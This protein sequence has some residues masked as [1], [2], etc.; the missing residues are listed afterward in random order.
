[1]KSNSNTEIDRYYVPCE[2]SIY[3]KNQNSSCSLQNLR[4]KKLS[5]SITKCGYPSDSQFASA[6]TTDDTV[7]AFG[8]F[9]W[10]AVVFAN[11][12]YI[13]AGSLIHPK[14]V[15][16][17]ALC[18]RSARQKYSVRVGEWDRNSI[19][20][21]LGYANQKV[22]FILIHPKYETLNLFYNAALLIVKHSFV[23]QPHIKTICLANH[24]EKHVLN[25]YKSCVATG[26]GKNTP[27]GRFRFKMKKIQFSLIKQRICE[28]QLRYSPLGMYYNLHKTFMCGINHQNYDICD[29]DNGGPFV[30]PVSEQPLRF[31][32]FGITSISIDCVGNYPTLFTKVSYVREWIDGEFDNL[33]YDKR[34]YQM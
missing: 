33:G 34:Y 1:M 17:S 5:P 27:T 10:T 32:Q 2:N 18:V 12:E 26:W 3:I 6:F 13:C 7:S 28:S 30:C 16:T 23:L 8:E 11:D 14:V 24:S 19:K 9:P 22:L 21:P 25:F 29:G 31:Q 4:K 20:E 15:L